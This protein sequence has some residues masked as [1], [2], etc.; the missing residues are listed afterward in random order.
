M[1]ED[2]KTLAREVGCAFD[3]VFMA[4]TTLDPAG[5]CEAAAGT[6]RF[7]EELYAACRKTFCLSAGLPEPP[8]ADRS[9][10]VLLSPDKIRPGR[11]Y[12]RANPDRVMYFEKAAR[13]IR[14]IFDRIKLAERLPQ[15]VCCPG[16]LEALRLMR[17]ALTAFRPGLLKAVKAVSSR[18]RKTKIYIGNAFD[19]PKAN[20]GGVDPWLYMK[21]AGQPAQGD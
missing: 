17:Q 12:V 15:V 8:D 19:N 18:T 2:I 20:Y 16:L 14:E 3:G 21:R 6:G 5:L 10:S 11:F 7:F 13:W 4:V 1:T 9:A